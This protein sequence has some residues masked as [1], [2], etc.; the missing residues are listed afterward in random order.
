M[1]LTLRA[2]L[3]T[4]GADEPETFVWEFADLPI[5]PTVEVRF[6]EAPRPVEV[7]TLE[8]E[9]RRGEPYDKVHIIDLIL[10]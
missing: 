1:D 2:S 6:W 7:M 4:A 5:D 10:R 8:V 9:N 3:Q